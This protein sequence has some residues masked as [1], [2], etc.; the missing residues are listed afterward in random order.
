MNLV[1]CISTF[2]IA[3][4][5]AFGVHAKAMVGQPAPDFE[6]TSADGSTVKLS[7][8]SDKYVIL[9]WTNHD[10]PFV[11]KH[12]GA[13]NMQQ[14]QKD[15][16][17][18]GVVWLSIISSANGKQGHVDAAKANALTNKRGAAPS[19]VLLDESGDVGRLYGA[20][21]TPHMYIISPD[22]MLAYMG[23][24]DSIKSSNPADIANATNYVT[25]AMIELNSNKPVSQTITKPYGCS[26]KY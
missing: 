15:Q 16:T 26:V 12:Y 10:C 21:T 14:L 19:H 3:T 11:K 18:N 5:M 22:G 17:A 1:K 23:A 20:K 6:L 25:Q 8:Y 7:D 24:I 13:G 4:V 2:V 9:E